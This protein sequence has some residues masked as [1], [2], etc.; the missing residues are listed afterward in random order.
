MGVGSRLEQ[1]SWKGCEALQGVLPADTV[2]QLLDAATALLKQEP[3]VIDVR[4]PCRAAVLSL[5]WLG[6]V[7]PHAAGP[8]A[9]G[10]H[11]AG[12]SGH[13]GGRHARAAA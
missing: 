2:V 8:C 5:S 4:A 7:T 10:A 11:R 12:R 1:A 3:T 6:T 9:G 13:S